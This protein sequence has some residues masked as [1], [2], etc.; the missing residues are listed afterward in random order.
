MFEYPKEAY[1][2]IF[3]FFAQLFPGTNSCSEVELLN[4]MIEQRAAGLC[5]FIQIKLIVD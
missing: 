1:V 4:I 3:V 5:H 2:V